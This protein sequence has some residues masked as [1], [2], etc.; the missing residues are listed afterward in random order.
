MHNS[1]IK[2]NLV[3]ISLFPAKSQWKSFKQLDILLIKEKV[4]SRTYCKKSFS[5][6]SPCY[7]LLWQMDLISASYLH[8]TQTYCH[9]RKLALKTLAFK[10]L[11]FE[12]SHSFISILRKMLLF[13]LS[14]VSSFIFA[15]ALYPS[16]V[17]QKK[18]KYCESQMK[19]SKTA[20]IFSWQ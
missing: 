10:T 11:K 9:Y 20:D 4:Y 17:L 12:I 16:H 13:I 15:Q 2:K 6:I 19:L 18:E 14:S 1:L 8:S 5:L 7:F 3:T